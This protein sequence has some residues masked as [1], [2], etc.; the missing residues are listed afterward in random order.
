MYTGATT[1]GRNFVLGTDKPTAGLMTIFCR[2]TA[3]AKAVAV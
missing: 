2:R 1:I 3:W